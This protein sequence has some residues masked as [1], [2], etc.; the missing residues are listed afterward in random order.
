[1]GDMTTPQYRSARP[2]G[3][4]RSSGISRGSLRGFVISCIRMASTPTS[5][6]GPRLHRGHCWSRAVYVSYS[7]AVCWTGPTRQLLPASHSPVNPLGRE[8]FE[9]P[10][11]RRQTDVDLYET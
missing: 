10:R 6:S 1:M 4:R 11:S 9:R 8:N 7:G 3:V 5:V 2:L